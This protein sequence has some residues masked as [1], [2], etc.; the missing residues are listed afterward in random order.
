LAV[1]VNKSSFITHVRYV[2][3]MFIVTALVVFF[4]QITKAIVRKNVVIRGTIEVIKGFFEISYSENT[5]AVFGM[6]QGRNIVFIIVG[7][8]AISF[9]F[10]YYR[11]FKGSLWMKIS[12]GMILG[13]ALGNL[14]DRIF[15][16]YVTDFIRIRLWFFHFFWWP[17]FNIADA[18]V[19]VG[20]AMLVIGMFKSRYREVNP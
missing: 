2:A 9:V 1:P 17:N 6:F 18:A 15:L 3:P 13:G 8:L 5:G 4:D 7:L 16:G 20:T 11:Q 12:F 10:V 19:C 14:M